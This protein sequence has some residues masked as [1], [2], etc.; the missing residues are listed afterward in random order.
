M[1]TAR[2]GGT[3]LALIVGL[4]LAAPVGLSGINAPIA[5][6][7]LPLFVEAAA[8]DPI[9]SEM[10]DIILELAGTMVC[11]TAESERGANGDATSA[12]DNDNRRGNGGTASVHDVDNA[13][14]DDSCSVVVG[15]I[16]TGDEGNH[17]ITADAGI[18]TGP[19]S[20]APSITDTGVDVFAPDCA[21]PVET[22]GGSGST[23]D[24]SGNDGDDGRG[25][26]G[27]NGDDSN[28]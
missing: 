7:A 6:A 28:S 11:S 24:A 10:C 25:A 19:V 14:E 9:S 22:A 13:R 23:I 26:T 17:T 15:D 20:V 18:V 8:Q 1:R 21:A 2:S 4:T 16:T 12:D 5:T 27:V 3:V